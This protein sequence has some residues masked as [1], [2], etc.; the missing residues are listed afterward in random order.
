MKYNFMQV[1]FW[2]NEID[3]FKK[4]QKILDEELNKD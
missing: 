4:Y 1:T 3:D 2:F